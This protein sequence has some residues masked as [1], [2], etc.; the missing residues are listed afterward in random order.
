M[1]GHIL[2]SALFILS[3]ILLSPSCEEPGQNTEDGWQEVG[4]PQGLRVNQFSFNSQGDIFICTWWYPDEPGDGGAIHRIERSAD[5]GNS[6]ASILETGWTPVCATIDAA[7][8]IYAGTW[9]KVS[10]SFNYGESWET[11][12]DT[13]PISA[14]HTIDISPEGHIYIGANHVNYRS[15]DNG[16]H[17]EALSLEYQAVTFLF[18]KNGDILAGVNSG[19]FPNPPQYIYRSTDDGNS[20]VKVLTANYTYEWSMA[21]N[22]NGTVFAATSEYD[23]TAG[24]VYRSTD[25]GLTWTRVNNGLPSRDVN[26]LAV[27]SLGHVF[28]GIYGQGIYRSI[29]D[30]ETWDDVSEDLTDLRIQSLGIDINDILFVGTGTSSLPTSETEDANIFR[31]MTITS[32][33]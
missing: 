14:I 23:S 31:R 24:G 29:D 5:N 20:W 12:I 28:I 32:V 33:H 7:D 21:A 22:Q 9:G 19:Y 3:V 26:S 13:L 17:W 15:K 25:N 16:A 10:R 11:V 4:S 30:G 6:W 1:K 27:N 18:L 8:N 2:K